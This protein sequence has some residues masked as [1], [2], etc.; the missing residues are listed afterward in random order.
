VH[1][2]KLV[3]SAAIPVV[4]FAVTGCGGPAVTP[5][6]SSAI[7]CMGSV[8]LKNPPKLTLSTD[9]PA[10]APWWGGDPSYQFPNEPASGSGWTGGEPYSME[11]FEGGVAY[12]LGNAMGFEYDEIDWVANGG[13]AETYASGAKP[14]EFLISHVPVRTDRETQVDFSQSYF[15]SQQSVVA[16]D[17]N[18]LASAKSVA[19]LKSHHL[20][21][22]AQS[23]SAAVI[24][25]VVKPTTEPT[26][27]PDQP[28]AVAA[29]QAGEIDGLVIDVQTAHYLT[30]GWHEAAEAPPPIANA[31]VVGQFPRS[32]WVD[33]FAIVLAKGSPV[34][35]CVNA[36]I[37][38]IRTEN[39]L[40][41]YTEEYIITG[42]VPEFT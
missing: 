18:A 28:A 39:F 16:L 24:D 22:V 15:E 11:G 37:D 26:V 32:A 2:R 12:S 8:Q 17:S 34:T 23:S 27:Y 7:D 31:E 1:F 33:R 30:E 9:D 29:L 19:D 40:G 10:T 21:A 35:A 6:P 42:D 36:A 38:Q 25:T 14:Y 3:A 41:E 13:P 20:G 4:A 5:K